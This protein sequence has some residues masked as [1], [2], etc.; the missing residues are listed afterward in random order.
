MHPSSLPPSLSPPTYRDTVP[1]SISKSTVKMRD[2]YRLANLSVDTPTPPPLS[3]P[4]F[5]PKA[6][7]SNLPQTNEIVQFHHDSL[8]PLPP[9]FKRGGSHPECRGNNRIAA[10][11]HFYKYK[12]ERVHTHT[13]IHIHMD[14]TLFSALNNY[15]ERDRGRRR[16]RR[17]EERG[18][19][20]CV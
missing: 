6:R 19:E 9:Y 12:Y 18:G 1:R 5:L 15:R 10:R 14:A 16:E 7:K 11:I 2:T 4:P 17:R 3:S 20:A 13:H 8:P